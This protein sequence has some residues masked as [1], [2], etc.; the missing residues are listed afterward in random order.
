MSVHDSVG[1]DLGGWCGDGI[2]TSNKDQWGL[3]RDC[4]GTRRGREAAVGLP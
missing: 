1:L 2:E 4:V 3:E